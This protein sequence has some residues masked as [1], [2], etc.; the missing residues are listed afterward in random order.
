[1]FSH[2]EKYFHR[3]C[4]AWCQL[5]L[6]PVVQV[7]G[8]CINVVWWWFIAM[9]LRTKTSVFIKDAFVTDTHE[10]QEQ[11]AE[12]RLDRK[13]KCVSA[14]TQLKT[15]ETQPTHNIA[16]L[17]Y[18]P[19]IVNSHVPLP[20]CSGVDL[21]AV[22]L[23]LKPY[24]CNR[25]PGG[26]SNLQPVTFQAPHHR[27]SLLQCPFITSII[28]FLLECLTVSPHFLLLARRGSLS[29][30]W[31]QT[32]ITFLFCMLPF[33]QTIINYSGFNTQNARLCC[34][35]FC[36]TLFLHFSQRAV[37]AIIAEHY[38][39]WGISSA[40][41]RRLTRLIDAFLALK[42]NNHFFSQVFPYGPLFCCAKTS[43]PQRKLC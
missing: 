13:L 22:S 41:S 42:L 38:L 25:P 20:M 36:S 24:L 14:A 15:G 31:S 23:L 19:A 4:H 21:C 9:L 2:V 17:I 3:C 12:W 33:P 27:A 35:I 32:L 6:I 29:L 34:S 43:R 7:V 8:S 5:A 40:P 11:D 30:T 39:W 18:I 16:F 1:M 37:T 10:V 26:W 28:G